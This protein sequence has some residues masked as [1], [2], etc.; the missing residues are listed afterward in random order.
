MNSGAYDHTVFFH[1][2]S[3]KSN[4][5]GTNTHSFRAV[6]RVPPRVIAPASDW[7]APVSERTP[8]IRKKWAA[9]NA[10]RRP[11][12]RPPENDAS[13]AERDVSP[14]RQTRRMQAAVA[15]SGEVV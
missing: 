3:E 13:L 2:P 4:S 8:R 15:Q 11:F 9:R 10:T 14:R 12:E 7:S 5:V 1:W 6:K